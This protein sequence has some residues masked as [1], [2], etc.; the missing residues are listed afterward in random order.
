MSLSSKLIT[1]IDSL[2]YA[3][4]TGKKSSLKD[5]ADLESVLNPTTIVG[6]DGS[7]ATVFEIYGSTK[8]IG[9]EEI[10]DIEEK[11][12]STLKSSLQNEG[13]QLQFVFSKDKEKIREFIDNTLAPYKKAARIL[14]MNLDDMFE[15]KAEHLEKFCCYESCYIVAWSTPELIRDTLKI[16][17]EENAKRAAKAPVCADSQ[18]I[19]IEYDRLET[20]HMAFCSTIKRAFEDASIN[21]QELDV[22]TALR[23][24]RQS[25]DYDNT[26]PDWEASLP[27]K[28]SEIQESEV[29]IP[30]RDDKAYKRSNTDISDLLWP[31]IAE[32]VFPSSV[33]IIDNN[34]IKMGSRYISSLYFDIPPQNI[35]SFDQLLNSLGSDLPFQISFTLESGGL[36]KV[37]M[38]AMAASILAVTNAGNKMVRDSI[39]S[40]RE[41]ELEG[42]SIIKMSINVITW[43]REEKEL[44]IRK[45]TL[46]KKL[47]TWGNA[48]I[49][50][51]NVDPIEGFLSTV[52]GITKKPA[53]T[54]AL[55]PLIDVI[56][57]LPLTRQSHVWEKGS[58]IFRTEDGKVFP[59]QPGSS[60]QTTWNDLIFAIPGSGK[61]VLMNAMNLASMIQPGTTELP[62]IGM[63]DI[64]PSS[65][66]VVQLVRD[67][68]PPKLKH[69]AIYKRI[70]NSPEY[71]INIFDTHLGC[72]FPTPTDL[73]FITKLITLIIT[74][75]GRSKPYESSNNLVN[76]V[77]KEAYNK[78][79]DSMDSTPKMY[80]QGVDSEVDKKLKEYN[81]NAE[82]KNM[83]W[84]AIVDFLF[85]KKEIHMAGRAQRYAVPVLEE[86]VDIATSTPAIKDTYSKPVAET[87]ENMLQLFQRTI[88]EAV[89]EFPMLNMPTVFDLSES[90]IISLDLDEVTKGDDD[91]SK[92]QSAIMYM[93]ARAIVGKNFKLSPE[94][95]HEVSP[96]K[97]KNYNVKR[98][99]LNKEIKKRLC[100]DEFHRTTGISAVRNQ[101]LVDQREGRKWNLQVL[102]ASQLVGDFDDDM[103]EV[104]TGVFIMSGGSE[105]CDNLTKMFHLNNTTCNI[106]KNKLNG[107]TSRGV[108]F[109]FNCVTKEGRYSQYLYATLSPIE[110]WALTT[111]AEDASL[112]D[113]LTEELGDSSLARR[114]LAEQFKGGTAKSYIEKKQQAATTTEETAAIIPNIIK[115]LKNKHGYI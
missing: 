21:L 67:A 99:K 18:N 80:H 5:Y 58:V 105:V 11:L 46:N 69:L 23:S 63:I 52:P 1:A 87:Q 41:L 107:P 60:L 82:E 25:V 65:K 44:N 40:L 57:M 98:A 77:I 27:I 101:V 48:Q 93:L 29:K 13:H 61:S 15:S 66:G 75:A 26:S 4:K 49:A 45:Q 24:I 91:S 81:I 72:R 38:K 97:Y 37:K 43:A 30:L 34:V 96:D 55:A 51:N 85:D 106:V 28:L 3:F 35:M 102:L 110:L 86:L 47:Q 8:F 64:G 113:R 95:M 108:P 31:S 6:K 19:I 114:L 92:K 83:S 32:Q 20:T 84:W 59:F 16:Q 68:L 70:Q 71:G 53:A 109:V 22:R 88:S 17:Q 10:Y 9:P 115:S 79:N 33:N 94:E 76:S 50:F 42:E 56:K 78:F 2:I 7:M 62:Y 73:A 12:F 39:N 36:N 112:R 54:G 74:P 90:R 100:I 14:Q 104:S 111:T 89:S 103:R